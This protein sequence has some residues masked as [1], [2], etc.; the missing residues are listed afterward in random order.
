MSSY[1]V[2]GIGYD[3]VPQ[4]LDQD[5]VDTWVKTADRESFNLARRLIREEGLL[6]GGSSGSAMFAALR[7]AK[8]LKAG[9]NCVVLLADGVRNYM[10]KFIDDKW[11]RDN[12]FL[13]V[14]T[15][16][17]KVADLLSTKSQLVCLAT[18]ATIDEAVS[19]MSSRGISQIPVTSAGHLVGMVREEDILQYLSSGEVT[20]GTQV[21]IVMDRTVA[22]VQPSTPI[23]ALQDILS[24]KHSVVVIDSTSSP[25]HIV[26]RI[27]LVEWL[28]RQVAAVS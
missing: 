7:E 25:T 15:M 19:Q 14:R 23:E 20:A 13:G 9:Q 3:F 28:S 27:D 8:H 6:C 24:Q 4:V 22:T 10:T 16:A 11:M 26:T 21:D 18:E 5:M 1:K 12:R 2:E 17:G